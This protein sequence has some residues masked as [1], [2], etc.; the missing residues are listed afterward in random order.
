MTPKRL[1]IRTYRRTVEEKIRFSTSS[2]RVVVVIEVV[3][4]LKILKGFFF[5]MS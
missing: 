5:G 3:S 4:I 1:S 2:N